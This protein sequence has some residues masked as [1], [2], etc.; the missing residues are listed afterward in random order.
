MLFLIF[1]LETVNFEKNNA[2]FQEQFIC[3][4]EKIIVLCVCL[5]VF[6]VP[7]TTKVIWRL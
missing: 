3:L 7:P 5:F 6:I 4:H 1:F 2:K